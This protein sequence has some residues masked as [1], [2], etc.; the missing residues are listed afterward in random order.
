MKI[1]ITLIT[2]LTAIS[3]SS[4]SY[5]ASTSTNA[6]K[7]TTLD[8]HIT[9]APNTVLVPTPVSVPRISTEENEVDYNFIS[10]DDC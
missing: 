7:Q 1:V 8:E 3:I 5:A 9:T 6:T 10:E 4:I 2:F